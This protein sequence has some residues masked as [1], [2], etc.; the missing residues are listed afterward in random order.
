MEMIHQALIIRAIH[1]RY[2]DEA[3]KRGWRPRGGQ[4][5]SAQLPL[6]LPKDRRC[7]EVRTRALTNYHDP[8]WVASQ[9]HGPLYDPPDAATDVLDH[10]SDRALRKIAV[11]QGRHDET[12][13]HQ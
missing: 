2:A 6:G 7:A 8:P 11:V 4:T 12:L 10:L 5:I 13:L 1:T 3:R 9:R